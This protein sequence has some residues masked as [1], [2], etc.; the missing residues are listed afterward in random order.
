MAD[1]GAFGWIFLAA[2]VVALI[3]TAMSYRV[4]HG[5]RENM[6]VLSL[7]RGC[8]GGVLALAIIVPIALLVAWLES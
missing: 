8:I 3:S 1:S 5:R 7:K 4:L 6:L 2:L